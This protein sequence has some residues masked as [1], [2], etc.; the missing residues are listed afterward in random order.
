MK[1]IALLGFALA[2]SPTL[3]AAQSSPSPDAAA[4]AVSHPSFAA[5]Q[6]MHE[7]LEQIHRQ[8]RLQML[9]SLTPAHRTLLASVIGQLAISANP[10]RQVAARS[11]DAALSQNEQR[12]VLSVATNAHTQERSLMEAART[13]FEASL[14][15]EQRAAMQERMASHEAQRPAG[16]ALAAKEPADAGMMLLDLAIGAGH[17][18]GRA[19]GFRGPGP[20]EPPPQ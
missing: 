17:E 8:A 19:F 4:P 15:P 7:Q 14:T 6:Q 10:D 20:G 3:V 18:G 12:S 16:M 2:M 13:Q 11:L 9:A 5:M 1:S